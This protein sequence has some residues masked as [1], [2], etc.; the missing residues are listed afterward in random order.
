MEKGFEISIRDYSAVI[1]RLCKRCR[2]TEAKYF[3]CMMLSDG[4][5]PDQELCEVMLNVFDQG[6]DF[7]SAAELLAE[8]IKFGFHPD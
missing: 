5:F 6:G 2:I 4:I 7:D 8:M 3:F 1:N